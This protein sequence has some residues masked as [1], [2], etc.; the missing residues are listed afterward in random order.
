MVNDKNTSLMVSVIMITYNHELY[1]AEAI[2]GILMQKCDFQIEL[3][4]SDDCSPD[5]TEKVVNE[6]VENHPNGSWI[7]YTKNHKNKGVSL[8]FVCAA[9]RAR[10]K[11][12]AL[13]E[14]DDYWT[15]PLKMQKQ[16]DFLE[17][18]VDYVACQHSREVYFANGKKIEQRF[19][20]YVFTQCLLFKNI[21]DDIFYQNILD[22]FNGDTFLRYYLI[23]NGKYGHLD[24]VGAV[25]RSNGE[26]VYSSIGQSSKNNHIIKTLQNV[27]KLKK[28]YPESKYNNIFV[29]VD[30]LIVEQ[31]FVK[32]ISDKSKKSFFLNYCKV[33]LQKGRFLNFIEYKRIFYYLFK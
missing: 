28:Y 32:A 33:I 19:S 29:E 21:L 7:K 15:D 18:N 30:D 24:F 10:G 1:I 4:I 3:I 25:Y 12:I 8:N 22:V 20:P 16:V 9:Q 14:G 13:C 2:N 23:L 27:L 5:N 26:G 11:Y 17:Q 31:I 6:I